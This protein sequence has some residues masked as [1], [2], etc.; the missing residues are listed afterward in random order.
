[1][2]GWKEFDPMYLGGGFKD[3]LFLP[4]SLEKMMQFDKYFSNGLK[5]PARYISF[6]P[7]MMFMFT[8]REETWTKALD[9][10]DGFL[11]HDF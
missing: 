2:E 3:V 1:M 10:V 9:A 8:N 7:G 5:Q 11:L 4:R 6:V